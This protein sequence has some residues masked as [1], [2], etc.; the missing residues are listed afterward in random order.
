MYTEK[1]KI[2][3]QIHISPYEQNAKL[4]TETNADI[5]LNNTESSE[6][7]FRKFMLTQSGIDSDSQA[8]PDKSK[9][10]AKWY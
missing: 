4:K 2:K 6:I 10:W 8:M 3:A 9:F 1:T 5:I 7:A